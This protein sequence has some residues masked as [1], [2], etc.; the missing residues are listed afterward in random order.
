MSSYKYRKSHC[1]D[2]TIKRP[3]YLHNGISYTGKMT[4]LYWIKGQVC[5][6]AFSWNA[7][8]PLLFLRVLTNSES[9]ESTGMTL[10]TST[11]VNEMEIAIDSG[12]CDPPTPPR[13]LMIPFSC[14]KQQ[15]ESLHDDV[16]KWKY[17]PRHWPFV[18]EI[19]R[20]PV[21]FSHKGQW[22]GALMV[23][24]ICAWT[25]SWANNEDA[26]GLRRHHADYDVTV[27]GT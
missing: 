5:P 27:M 8:P 9:G 21:N 13:T 20:S 26:S 11:M 19:H 7:L 2:K 4:S 3:S 23:S 10:A 1:G 15:D 14:C 16:I 25:N 22:R 6:T 24:L 12:C 17:F 18:Q